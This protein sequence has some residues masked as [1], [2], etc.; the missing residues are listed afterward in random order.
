MPNNPYR[1]RGSIVNAD[2]FVGR[3][4]ILSECLAL[5]TTG[6]SP[7]NVSIHG[8]KW[9]GKTWLLRTVQQRL[10]DRTE[11]PREYLCILLDVQGIGTPRTF[12]GRLNRELAAAARDSSVSVDDSAATLNELVKRTSTT[13]RTVVVLDGFDAITRNPNFPVDFFSFL[14]SLPMTDCSRFGWLLSSSRPLREMCHSPAVQGSPFFNIFSD[15]L[16]SAFT[17][18]DSYDLISRRSA[19]AG[20]PLENYADQIQQLAGRFPLFLQMACCYAFEQHQQNNSVIDLAG[21]SQK[22]REEVRPYV[23]HLWSELNRDE[24]DV[25]ERVAADAPV[26]MYP[27]GL[28]RDL[29]RRGYLI[30]P[31]IGSGAYALDCQAFA[32]FLRNR[33]RQD[34]PV[35]ASTAGT[36]ATARQWQEGLATP[37]A[38][39][40]VF[41]SYSHRNRRA[42]RQIFDYV[43]SLSKDG[44][45]FWFDD[46]LKA[47]D[48]WDEKIKA[49]MLRADIAVVLASQEY[50]TSTYCMETEAAEFVRSRA[51]AGMV[52]F[53]VLLSPCPIDDHEWLFRTHRLP[54]EGN[55]A[56][57]ASSKARRDALLLQILK[58]L[59]SVATDIRTRRNVSPA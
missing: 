32:D 34:S 35:K 54:R 16:L 1:N 17:S 10:R 50:F 3:D 49:E 53:P 6:D 26:N 29:V 56:Q 28:L 8:D 58:E 15:R 2:E 48:I 52:I 12:Y 21:V 37:D 47:G 4:D 55:F 39:V 14:R 5:I 19:R 38:R 30:G 7:Q 13:T 33:R 57:L 43:C 44:V 11:D 31:S 40:R 9:S 24:Q 42:F 36:P 51:A 41:I 27:T 22:F 20:R 46:R 18:D 25:L 23:H 59:R 45:E